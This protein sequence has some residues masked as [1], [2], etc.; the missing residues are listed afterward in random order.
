MWKHN[1]DNEPEKLNFRQPTILY[2]LMDGLP[3]HPWYSLFL[4]K[5]FILITWALRQ[6]SDM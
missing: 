3:E 2:T 5:L 6:G 4:S 1:L